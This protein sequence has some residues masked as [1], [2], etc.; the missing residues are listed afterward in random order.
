MS[1][2]K[3]KTEKKFALDD[4]NQMPGGFFI[5]KADWDKEEIIYANKVMLDIFECN[6]LDEFKILTNNSFSGIVHPDDYVAV[7]KNIRTQIEAS[8]DH[9]DQVNYR[10]ITKTGKIKYIE[11]YGKYYESKEY[12]PLFYV[13]ISN[14]QIKID[15]LTGLPRRRHFLQLA[16][17]FEEES[18]ADQKVCAIAELNL[19]GLKNFN[20]KYG[21]DEGDILLRQ[22]AGLIIKNFGSQHSARFSDDNFYVIG[23]KN[24]MNT[25]LK[26]IVEEL[27]ELNNGRTVPVRIGV[28]EC[29]NILSIFC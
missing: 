27:K 4:L 26:N 14:A 23:L 21:L 20:S 3:R 15:T 19:I 5:Y 22:F 6:T 9:F 10:I 25:K 1:N 8:E 7:K 29:D 28:C 17:K 18:C 24:E 16:K 2:E 12:G 11:D 13:F